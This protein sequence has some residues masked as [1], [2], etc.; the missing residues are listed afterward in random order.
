MKRLTVRK[1]RKKRNKSNDLLGAVGPAEKKSP[2]ALEREL[3]RSFLDGR[4]MTTIMTV[5]SCLEGFLWDL[6]KNVGSL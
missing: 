4:T 6:F 1:K 2:R 5:A 3:E